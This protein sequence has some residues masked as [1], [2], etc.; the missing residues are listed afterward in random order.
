[1]D[2]CVDALPGRIVAGSE[3][4]EAFFTL[5]VVVVVDELLLTILVPLTSADPVSV[6]FSDK[7][8]AFVVVKSAA[9][10]IFV[11]LSGDGVGIVIGVEA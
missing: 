3:V 2:S 11:V 7:L 1:M 5:A 8:G 6:R 10:E 4:P 9:E